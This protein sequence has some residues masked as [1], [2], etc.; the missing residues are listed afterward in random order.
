VETPPPSNASPFTVALPEAP[1]VLNS[2]QSVEATVQFTATMSGEFSYTARLIINNSFNLEV[3]LTARAVT[4]E[5]FLQLFGT[6]FVPGTPNLFFDG[7]EGLNISLADFQS[8]AQE[9]LTCQPQPPTP[10]DLEIA[11]ALEELKTWLDDPAFEQ[12]IQ[13][14]MQQYPAFGTFVNHIQNE[15]LNLG[16]TSQVNYVQVLQTL[17]RSL[18]QPSLTPGDQPLPIPSWGIPSADIAIYTAL[19]VAAAEADPEFRN[20]NF[21]LGGQST[22]IRA[23]QLFVIA[24]G[25]ITGSLGPNCGDSCLINVAERLRVVAATIGTSAFHNQF[26]GLLMEV[27]VAFDLR[28]FWGWD[29]L[30]FS[31]PFL[32]NDG[33]RHEIDI[34]AKRFVPGIGEVVAY[35]EVK[36]DKSLSAQD[37]LEKLEHYDYYIKNIGEKRYQG[38]FH[39]VVLIS[40]EQTSATTVENALDKFDSTTP[41]I[42]IYCVSNCNGFGEGTF[43]VKSKNMT[44]AQVEALLTWLGFVPKGQGLYTSTLDPVS[45]KLLLMAWF[46]R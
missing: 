37:I 31:Q 39:V 17:A 42:I 26:K 21:F 44:P 30:N 46:S 34:I 11:Q 28:V 24:V 1:F 23:P 32:S 7:F 5:E 25:F 45:I 4:F 14:L 19:L 9:L 38:D 33:K 12:K 29:L 2:S 22:G 35:I 15:I 27:F 40:F 18:D 13:E 8:L 16:V 10:E 36:S 6:L 41:A 20:L 43:N 3:P